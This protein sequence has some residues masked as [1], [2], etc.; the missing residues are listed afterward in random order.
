MAEGGASGVTNLDASALVINGT[1]WLD[2][3]DQPIRG[4]QGNIILVGDEYYWFG[5]SRSGGFAYTIS[6]YHSRDLRHW[7]F[8]RDLLP[9]SGPFTRPHVI[10]NVTTGKYVMWMDELIDA[11][12]IPLA[13]VAE[14][15]TPDG[16]YTFLGDFRPYQGHGVRDPSDGESGFRSAFGSAFVDDDGKGYFLSNSNA[17]ADLNVY[18]L[19]DDYLA[20]DHP[21]VTLFPGQSRLAPVLFKRN[22]IYFLITISPPFPI[23]SPAFATSS[24]LAGPWTDWSDAGSE[25]PPSTSASVLRLPGSGGS[26]FLYIAD[27]G[28]GYVWQPLSFPAADELSMSK[29]TVLD[30]SAAPAKITGVNPSFTFINNRTGLALDVQGESS[31]AGARIVQSS[32]SGAKSQRWVPEYVGAGAFKLRNANSGKLFGSA[33]DQSAVEFEIEQVDEGVDDRDV[34]T[35]IPAPAGLYTLYH[36]KLSGALDVAEGA[37]EGAPLE[38]LILASAPEWSIEFVR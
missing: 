36:D 17:S 19:T 6:A 1:R 13:A 30:L 9:E 8:S 28:N 26:S 5:S 21:V 31:E 10:H 27:N 20:I 4:N 12:N 22:G 7:Q 23:G 37:G 11:G 16:D 35:L 3:D 25:V 2:V 15:D 24:S 14:S 32:P 38:P 29:D 34:I 18:Q 33:F